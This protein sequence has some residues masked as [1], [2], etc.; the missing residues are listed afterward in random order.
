VLVVCNGYHHERDVLTAA[1]A[2]RCGRR[3]STTAAR[4]RIPVNGC[5]FL[6]NPAS[7]DAV[8]AVRRARFGM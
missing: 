6:S 1:G 8:K 5:G 2:W 3:G 4:T 7:A